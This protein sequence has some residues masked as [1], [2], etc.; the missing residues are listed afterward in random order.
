MEMSK[1]ASLTLNETDWVVLLI[2]AIIVSY[3]LGVLTGWIVRK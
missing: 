1:V 2:S 3:W